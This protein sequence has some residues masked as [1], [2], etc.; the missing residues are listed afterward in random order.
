MANAD[1]V[2]SGSPL[3]APAIEIVNLLSDTEDS[4][5]HPVG[6]PEQSHEED[7]GSIDTGNDEW[8]MYEDA[9]AGALDHD[10]ADHCEQT[11]NGADL[12]TDIV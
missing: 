1:G 4:T 2:F 11:I 3:K 8:S 10:T 5:D 9:L 12:I 7:V 6:P